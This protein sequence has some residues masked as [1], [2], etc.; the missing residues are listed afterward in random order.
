MASSG[1]CYNTLRQ[2]PSPLRD[3]KQY[4]CPSRRIRF[5]HPGY[6]DTDYENVLLDLYAFDYP[7]GGLHY[8]TA[9]LACAIVALNAFNGYLSETRAGDKLV[10]KWDELLL[11]DNYYF[12]IP[13]IPESRL[14]AYEYQYLVHPTF[15]HWS[16]PHMYTC[17]LAKTLSSTNINQFRQCPILGIDPHSSRA[18]PR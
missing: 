5:R 4:Q 7:T 8:G 12:Y 6:P 14:S 15:Q 1:K 16:F 2:P 3:S 10:S 11:K 18:S 13:S 17:Q 9:F